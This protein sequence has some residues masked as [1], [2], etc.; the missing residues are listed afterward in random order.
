MQ[1]RVIE[2]IQEEW[3]F[4]LTVFRHLFNEVLVSVDGNNVKDGPTERKNEEFRLFCGL[5]HG[6]LNR[7]VKEE[8]VHGV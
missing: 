3:H 7:F 1:G 8:T 5:G 6:V 4:E 2:G